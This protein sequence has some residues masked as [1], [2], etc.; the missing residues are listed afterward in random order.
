MADVHRN[1]PRFHCC[2]P[3]DISFS[4]EKWSGQSE[5]NF[6]RHSRVKGFPRFGRELSNGAK[7]GWPDDDKS[8]VQFVGNTFMVI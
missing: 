4:R 1:Q 6:P 7:F 2:Q 5:T 8:S 3:I